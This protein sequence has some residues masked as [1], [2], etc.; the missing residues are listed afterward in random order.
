MS[1]GGV[2]RI[3]GDKNPKVGVKTYYNV[4][5]W[6]PETPHNER[7][8]SLVTWELYVKSDNGFISTGI[9]K[10]GVNYFTFGPDAHKFSYKIE[11][12]L[13]EAEGKEPMAIFV[14]PQKNENPQQAEKEILGINLTYQ[15]G[16]KITK[17]LS[18]M[19]RL[20]ATAKCQNLALHSIVFKLWEDDEAESGHNSKN[21]FIAKS[22]PRLVDSKGNA[23]WDFTL[24]N[25][26]ITLA[27]KREG[28]KKKHEYYVTA[29][30]NAKI[31][32]SENVNINN[33]VNK[34]S[35]VGEIKSLSIP[36]KK[37]KPKPKAN[38]AKFPTSVN[39]TKRQND[40]EGKVLKAEFVDS[41]G[42]KITSAKIGTSTIIKITSQ[43]LTKKIVKI[44]IW[45][46]DTIK[47]D[48]LFEKKLIIAGDVSFYTV[49]LTKAMYEKGESYEVEGN[50]EEF[51][52]EIE[53]LSISTESSRINVG[54]NEVP[55]KQDNKTSPAIVAKKPKEKFDKVVGNGKEAVLYITSEI[56]TEIKID[57]NDKITSYP[58]YGGYNGM[59]EYK[60]G[61]KLYCK[62]L[63]NGKS[64]FPLYNMYIYRGTKVGE[65]IKKLKQDIE[66]NT[67]ENAESTILTVARHAQTNNKN[68]GQSGP[69]P[70]NTITTLY[71]I[72][73]MQAWNH[74]KKESFRYRIVSNNL[75]NMKPVEKIS[76]E[77]SNGAMS[78]G[79]RS[80][81]S[82]DPWKSKDLIGCVGIRKADG[83]NHP[84]CASEMSDLSASNYKFVYH[85]LNNYLESVI[86]ELKGVYGRRGYSSNG[87]IAV[88][89][90]D[91][92][93]EIKVFV[94][95]D[96]LPEINGC[97]CNLEERRK[98]YYGS[99]GE[100]TVKYISEHTAANKFKGLYM[101]AQRR[102]ENGFSLKTPLNNP[103]NIKGIG[104]D[105]K[106]SL[107]TH[108]TI[109]G[110][111]QSDVGSFA[112]FTS[113]DA[114]FE[115]Y[116]KLLEK[117]YAHA[118]LSLTT[119]SMTIEDFVVGLEDEGTLGPYATGKAGDGISGTEQ[120]KT[121][122]KNNFKSVVKDY[123]KWLECK[124]C[125]TKD[126][127][128]KKK[129]KEDIKLLSQLK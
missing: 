115:G 110:I 50:S 23:R 101:V 35:A 92:K 3:K 55:K 15:D 56:G 105:G 80:S 122:V 46:D 26:Y 83:T 91:Y 63:P 52:I 127:E 111:Y 8:Q 98:K 47:D 100:K 119:N 10:K 88:A 120:Y 123:N 87:K 5:D 112:K 70:P 96:P 60:E 40:L 57:K 89:T 117:R 18:Y 28:E 103:M 54:L 75:S 30:Y 27:N 6:Y 44:R 76:S 37:P 49:P 59:L 84:S 20:R 21:Q 62:K 65:A 58:D 85:S 90:S 94:L 118:Y 86:P 42:N 121:A 67:H 36:S 17:T 66:Y 93:E 99:F 71:R 13:H 45:E 7:N 124:L 12:Y 14:E 22:P 82:L 95:T 51:Y 77:V 41:K 25:T 33:P 2:Y 78:L 129:I 16:S 48:L 104:D 29:E 38:T 73:Y 116:L 109:D 126:A 102:Q 31:E 69:L 107:G 113:D 32:A 43:N 125:A 128:E 114:G 81:I 19:D 106:K 68:Y 34:I 74:S 53:H 64:A 4:V 72:R 24:F 108:E 97:D 11:G 1:K 9:K 61:G 39:S 79:S